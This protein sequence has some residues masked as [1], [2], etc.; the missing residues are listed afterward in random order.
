VVA[1]VFFRKE[2]N[3]ARINHCPYRFIIQ[4]VGIDYGDTI[5]QSDLFSKMLTM[6]MDKP[7][8]YRFTIQTLKMGM[9]KPYPTGLQSKR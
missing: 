6:G 9:D 1:Q 5:A 8:P 3:G 7:Y 4:N 2:T